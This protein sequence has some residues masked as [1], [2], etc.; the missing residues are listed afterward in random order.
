MS[1]ERALGIVLF[2]LVIVLVVVVILV[3]ARSGGVT[4]M[5]LPTHRGEVLAL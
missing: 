3:I 5:P 2:L 4:S 1:I